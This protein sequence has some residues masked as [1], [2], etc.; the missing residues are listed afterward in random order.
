MRTFAYAKQNFLV[1]EE[2]AKNITLKEVA[3]RAG[4]SYQTVSKV[5]NRQ[6][7]VS[8][9]T[10]ARIWEVIRQLGYRPNQIARSMRSR[11]S[12][13]IGYSW[14]PTP[15]D[16]VN[17]ILDQFLQGMVRAAEEAG[18]HILAFPHRAGGS[19]VDGY[20]ELIQT[21]QV[22]G[23][24]ISSVEFDDPRLHFLCKEKIPFVAFGRSNPELDFPYVDVDGAAGIRMVVE[25]LLEVGHRRIA[26][27]AWPP[28]SRVGQN[29][30]EGYYQAMQA[31]GIEI[32]PSWLARG[33]GNYWFGWQATKQMLSL[34]LESRPTAFVAFN[35]AM[36]IGA[37]HAAQ[38]AGLQVGTEV[39]VTGFDDSPLIQYLS[40]PLTSVHQPIWE[41][42]QRIMNMLVNIL[43][44][45]PLE[46]RHVLITPRLVIRQSSTGKPPYP[47]TPSSQQA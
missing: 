6:I 18:Y 40:P 16:Q 33:E 44:G 28:T 19:E 37:M 4:V 24:V 20:R 9:E 17:S 23:F 11:R 21:N 3:A 26:A 13:K 14:A 7:R 34:P 30:L 12:W 27:L 41:I 39:A 35:D 15:M 45:H 1:C 38:E 5:I 8:E 25:H 31:A 36:A 2:M 46:N 43:E 10:E 42:G 29:R 32:N 22:D 47:S